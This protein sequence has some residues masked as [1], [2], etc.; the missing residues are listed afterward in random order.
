M[1]KCYRLFAT[2]RSEDPKRKIATILLDIL[3]LLM[4][5]SAY[6]IVLASMKSECVKSPGDKKGNRSTLAVITFWH[7]LSGFFIN[8]F[9]FMS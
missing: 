3:A 4:Q 5:L 1:S 7:L 6:V 2:K 8:K 9:L